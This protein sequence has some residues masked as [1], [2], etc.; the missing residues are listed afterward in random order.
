MFY[1]PLLTLALL[2]GMLTQGHAQDAEGELL[3]P[4]Q[5]FRATAT[6]TDGNL[7]QVDFAV[8]EGYY[9]YRSKLRFRSKTE[10]DTGCRPGQAQAA[11]RQDQT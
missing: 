2:A 9:L 8:A 6:A 10:R 11:R 7:A 4:E 3:P 5:A 1:R